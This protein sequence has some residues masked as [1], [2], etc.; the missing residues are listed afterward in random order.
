LI[1]PTGHTPW[2][3]RRCADPRIIRPSRPSSGPRTLPNARMTVGLRSSAYSTSNLTTMAL[4]G[5]QGMGT[6]AV[7]RLKALT[8]R[9]CKRGACASGNGG[10]PV[11]RPFGGSRCHQMF[12]S[13]RGD[14]TGRS[15]CRRSGH[16]D[17]PCCAV[18]SVLTRCWVESPPLVAVGMRYQPDPSDSTAGGNDLRGPELGGRY[19]SPVHARYQAWSSIS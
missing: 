1:S 16:R 4:S 2:K 13:V 6:S 18:P 7:A 5:C 12:H 19:A 9:S 8:Y 11:D 14:R 17:R 15:I 10:A 3:L